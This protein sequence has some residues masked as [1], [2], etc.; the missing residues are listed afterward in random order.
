MPVGMIIANNCRLWNSNPI[1][2][3]V[4]G[5]RGA[6]L[7]MREYDN[8]PPTPDTLTVTGTASGTAGRVRLTIST[9]TTNLVSNSTAIVSGVGGTTE[10][11][12]TWRYNVIDTTHI[13]LI[14]TTWANAWT[15]G[16]TAVVGT[17]NLA[18]SAGAFWNA[19]SQEVG[20][21]MF[22]S[23][24]SG[25]NYSNGFL[26]NGNCIGF[27]GSLLSDSASLSC[28]YGVVL[29]GGT[30][31]QAAIA[32][33]GQQRLRIYGNGV[34]VAADI[35]GDTSNNLNINAGGIIGISAPGAQGTTIL[36]N[37]SGATV[38]QA[39]YVATGTAYNAAATSMGVT[40]N[41]VT[42]RSINAGGTVNA[43][44]TDY[45]EYELISA[46]TLSRGVTFAKGDVV[47][48]DENGELT[49]KFSKAIQFGIKTTNPSYV[50]G[51]NWH[52]DLPAEPAAPVPPAEPK[53]PPKKTLARREEV[54][55]TI[56]REHEEAMAA[57]Q[58]TVDAYQTASFAHDGAMEAYYKAKAD[59]D[60][61]LEACRVKVDRVAYSGKVPVNYKGAKPGQYIKAEEGDNDTIVAGLGIKGDDGVVGRVRCILPDGRAQVVVMMT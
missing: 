29:G 25:G 18:N 31:S 41:S 50:G 23:G 11:N 52:V 17:L 5:I 9:N 32:I 59:W 7:L 61:L 43:S 49:D 22:V 1:I 19:F 40:A 6:G 36:V 2:S 33:L 13:D 57:W 30:Y 54:Q 15:S 58:A 48:F 26:F 42:S 55:A 8:E 24:V 35:S 10:A 20:N 53:D 44:G 34:S 38:C 45:A 28:K 3:N 39:L 14:G 56:D 47:G 16:G 51:D 12:G 27:D 21:L 60:A 4:A 37:K 46:D